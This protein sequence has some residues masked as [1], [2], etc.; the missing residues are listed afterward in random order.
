MSTKEILNG[1]DLRNR[2]G[3]STTPF[4]KFKKAGLPYHQLPGGR[5]YYLFDEVQIWLRQNGIN[6][7][8][9]CGKSIED[10]KM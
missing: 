6:K 3:I 8:Q 10:D 7:K 1:K 4:Y 9:E 5:P 2:L